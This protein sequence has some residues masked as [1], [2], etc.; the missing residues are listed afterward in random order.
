[1]YEAR[2]IICAPEPKIESVMRCLFGMRELEVEVY[3]ALIEKPGTP[4]EV[5][6]RLK[7][8]RSLVQR[9]LQN[10]MGYGLAYRSAVARKRG[11]AYEYSA[12]SKKTAK[13]IMIDALRKWGETVEKCVEAW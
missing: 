7:K 9:A 11:R 5:A 13:K 3:L 4:S 8:S 1:M 10:I 2:S 6:K 12:V